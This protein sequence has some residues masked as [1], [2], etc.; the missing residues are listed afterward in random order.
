MPREHYD[1][2]SDSPR[3]DLHTSHKQH[4]SEYQLPVAI[5]SSRNAVFGTFT[6]DEH[7]RLKL[8]P[9]TNIPNEPF[10]YYGWMAWVGENDVPVTWGV[11]LRASDTRQERS[12][13]KSMVPTDGFI[14][15]VWFTEESAG[16]HLMVLTLPGGDFTSFQY[17]VG[18]KRT[19]CPYRKVFIDWWWAEHSDDGD[20]NHSDLTEEVLQ[21]FSDRLSLHPEVYPDVVGLDDAY[22]ML[23]GIASV[24]ITDPEYA[25]GHIRIRA[26]ADFEGKA[27]RHSFA[28]GGERGILDKGLLFQFPVLS[29]E[30]SMYQAADEFAGAITPHI[31]RMCTDWAS[32]QIEEEA[33]LERIRLELVK[34]MQR[35]RRARRLRGVITIEAE[36]DY[37]SRRSRRLPATP[38]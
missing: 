35:I 9:T 36:E 22:W 6:T 32:G 31:Q 30:S 25:V 12:Y 8:E 27:L 20:P 18:P 37:N 24:S 26:I 10:Q 19:T 33:R 3:D 17:T 21:P 16:D 23:T 38:Q 11:S 2:S 28:S 15:E 4:G 1:S 13:R 7:G 34:E 29:M 14:Y 5:P